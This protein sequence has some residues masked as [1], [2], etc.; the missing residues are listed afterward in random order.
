MINKSR[1]RY[2]AIKLPPQKNKIRI[3]IETASF[4]QD[5]VHSLFESILNSVQSL[6]LL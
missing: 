3:K 2:A 1:K 4:I 5:I 6:L